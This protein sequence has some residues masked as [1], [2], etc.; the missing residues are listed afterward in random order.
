MPS[1][2]PL[3]RPG[4]LASN[5]FMRVTLLGLACLIAWDVTGFDRAMAHWFGSVNG[6]PLRANWFIVKVLHDATQNAGW[7]CLL[8]MTLGIFWPRGVLRRL[9]A[10]ER[11]GM[12]LGTLAALLAIAVLKQTS[13]TSCPW[14]LAEFGGTG[15]YMSHWLWGVKD[16]GGGHC[17]PAGHASTGFALLSGYFG[18]RREAPRAARW[19]LIGALATG[20]GLGLV[21]QLRG[22][23]FTSHTLWTAWICWT[24]TGLVDLA[25]RHRARVRALPAPI[26]L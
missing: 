5:R 12:V 11:G 7:L 9:T 17:F 1:N 25:M 16:G 26:G 15:T 10:G 23:H 21:Q 4:D 24:V 18:L 8:G 19:W 13:H 3:S 6:F 22:A 2:P 20:F 14:D